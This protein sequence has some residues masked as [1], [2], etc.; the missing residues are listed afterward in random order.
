MLSEARI[1]PFLAKK[2]QQSGLIVQERQPDEKS[3][4]TDEDAGMHAAAK[5]LMDAVHAKDIKRVAE[6]LRAAFQIADSEPHNEG[7]HTYDAQNE[8]AGE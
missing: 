4:G 2:T 3:E 5:D 1:L 7:P 6:A 8:E